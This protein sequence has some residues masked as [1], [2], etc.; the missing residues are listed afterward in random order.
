MD[1]R[2]FNNKFAELKKFCEEHGHM[3]RPQCRKDREEMLLGLWV[4]R[5]LKSCTVQQEDEIRGLA[6]NY[7][8]PCPKSKEDRFKDLIQF[9]ERNGRLPIRTRGDQEKSLY[10]FA[11]KHRTSP[12]FMAILMKYEREV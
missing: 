10:D 6:K 11:C 8:G 12:E 2:T 5:A 1:Q 3:P 4:F 7:P 9:C